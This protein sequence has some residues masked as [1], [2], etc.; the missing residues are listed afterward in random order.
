[1][2]G[3]RTQCSAIAVA[4]VASLLSVPARALRCE[5]KLISIGDHRSKL[6][7]YCGEPYLAESRHAQWA[8]VGNVGQAIFPAYA[9]D[10]L[11][12]EWTYNF[13]PNKLMRV[14]R[15]ENGVV[16]AIEGLGYGFVADD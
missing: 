4:V 2:R 6:L 5:H 10:L 15:L 1:M 9:E 16:A 3:K 13:G 14:V 8:L 12:E 7:R 11:I